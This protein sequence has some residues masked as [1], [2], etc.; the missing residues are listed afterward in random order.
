METVTGT[1]VISLPRGLVPFLPL[2][3]AMGD[4]GR[5]SPYAKH[6]NAVLVHAHGSELALGVDEFLGAQE[7]V[8]KSLGVPGQLPT[9][10]AGGT[11]L[12]DGG[13]ALVIDVERLIGPARAGWNAV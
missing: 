7:V 12:A 9:G 11:I 8:L 10:V 2:D 5:A 13:V 6:V 3:A 1:P 4:H